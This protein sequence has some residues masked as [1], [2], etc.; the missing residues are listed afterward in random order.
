MAERIDSLTTKKKASPLYVVVLSFIL[1][2]Q[3]LHAMVMWESVSATTTTT[4]AIRYHY[5]H[6]CSNNVWRKCWTATKKI[7]IIWQN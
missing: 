7:I 2:L 3:G 1:L 5:Y 4:A 6:G